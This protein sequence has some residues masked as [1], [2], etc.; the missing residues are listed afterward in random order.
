V[1]RVLQNGE[2]EPVGA[3]KTVQVD[4][5]VVAATNREL[6]G[7]IKNGRFREDLFYRLNVVPIRTPPLRERLDDVPVLVDWFTRRFTQ[8][9]NYRPKRFGEEA[10]AQLQAMP[11]RGNVRELRNLVERLLILT[12]GDVIERRDV[13]AATGAQQA[14]L[15]ESLFSLKALRDFRDEAERLFILHKLEVN[16]WNVT[17]TAQAIDTPRS[18]LYKKMEQ[19]GIRR[20]GVAA[21]RDAAEPGEPADTED[22]A[23]VAGEEDET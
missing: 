11:W 16:D 20:A 23:A 10:I 21:E 4:V 6:E 9:D 12:P 1:L 22:A 7:E 8:A 19:Y 14:A 15:P 18:N 3:E 5:R 17:Q 2:V 13:L